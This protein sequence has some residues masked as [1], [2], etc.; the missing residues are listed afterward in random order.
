[1]YFDENLSALP[2][3]L[4]SIGLHEIATK[5]SATNYRNTLA[6]LAKITRECVLSTTT[7]L[8]NNINNMDQIFEDQLLHSYTVHQRMTLTSPLTKLLIVHVLYL[9]TCKL[10]D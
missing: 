10:L 4:T 5:L 8:D 7:P 9:H 3:V 6:Q 2:K 1:M